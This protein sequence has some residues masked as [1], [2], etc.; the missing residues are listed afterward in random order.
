MAHFN[1]KAPTMNSKFAQAVVFVAFLVA[2]GF[3]Y[4]A[5]GPFEPVLS[6]I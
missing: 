1:D 3:F 5:V 6:L 4:L 2:F